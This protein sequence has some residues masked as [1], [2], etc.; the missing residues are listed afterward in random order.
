MSSRNRPFHS[1]QASPTKLPT[2]YS[3]AASH[4]SAM[5]FVPASAGSDSMSQ[6]TGGFGNTRPEGSRVRMEARSNR[7]PSTCI[8][9]TQ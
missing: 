1:F 7:N 6:S 4:A 3:P 9:A 5:S 8:S 2:W